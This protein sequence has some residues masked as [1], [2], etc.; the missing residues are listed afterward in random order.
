MGASARLIGA[1]PR[2][3]LVARVTAGGFAVAMAA[4]VA[5]PVAEVLRALPSGHAAAAV[6]LLAGLTAG[7]LWLV[8]A[9][10]AD[11]PT[12]AD[13][14]VLAATTGLSVAAPFVV[15]PSWLVIGFMPPLALALTLRGWRAFA[16]FAGALV[17]GAVLTRLGGSTWVGYGTLQNLLTAGA[18]VGLVLF[19][20][21]LRELH[22][23]RQELAT[24][25]VTEERLRFARELHDVLGHNLSV[26]AMKTELAMRISAE[27]RERLHAEL[28]D[29][30]GIARRSLHDVRAVVKGYREMSLERELGGVRRVLQAAGISCD[31]HDIPATLD[32]ATKVAL[33]WAVREAATNILRHSRATVCNLTVE[34][35]DKRGRIRIGLSN[36]GA[37]AESSDTDGSGLAGVRER[38]TQVGGT[39]TR[40]TTQDG[41]FHLVLDVPREPAAATL[42]PSQRERS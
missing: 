1:G 18:L 17:G 40:R 31:F 7:Y 35:D 38:L 34:Q 30:H 32:L 15:G 13:V 4:F 14:P 9:A 24:L 3:I 21:L 11:R 8:M 12:R 22:R 20:A 19:A 26:I 28:S 27:Q 39:S 42:V 29:I 23:T 16:G 37:L 10:V 33:A 41:W 2:T 6:V 36:D 25:A 5:I